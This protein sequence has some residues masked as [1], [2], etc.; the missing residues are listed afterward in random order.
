[1]TTSASNR[2]SYLV[3]A[4]SV[5][6]SLP[7][8]SRSRTVM[9]TTSQSPL[10]DDIRIREFLLAPLDRQVVNKMDRHFVA[11][12]APDIRRQPLPSSVNPIEARCR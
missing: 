2:R 10:I 7:S 8:T 12:K 1:M 11:L 5:A 4:L 9:T 3:G 6:A